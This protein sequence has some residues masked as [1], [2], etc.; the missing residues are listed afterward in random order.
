MIS[1]AAY[2]RYHMCIRI[3]AHMYT[4]ELGFHMLVGSLLF[5]DATERIFDDYVRGM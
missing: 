1:E 2:S 4:L 5:N 3:H